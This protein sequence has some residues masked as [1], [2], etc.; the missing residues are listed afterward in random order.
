MEN[1]KQTTLSCINE[2]NICR[3]NM[4]RCK[5]DLIACSQRGPDNLQKLSQVKAYN[6][7]IQQ[8]HARII[9]LQEQIR[10]YNRQLDNLKNVVDNMCSQIKSCNQRLSEI[11]NQADSILDTVQELR[12]RI[13]NLKSQITYEN[14]QKEGLLVAISKAKT[15]VSDVQSSTSQ[16][17]R[18]NDSGVQEFAPI[19]IAWQAVAY[20]KSKIKL[21]ASN[22]WSDVAGS[23]GFSAECVVF[24]RIKGWIKGRSGTRQIARDAERAGCGN[25]GEQAA[26]A[27]TW[28]VDQKGIAPVDYMVN[29]RE[30]DYNSNHA[31]VV[32]G[33]KEGSDLQ[34]PSTWGRNA[35]VCDPWANK[36]YL[37][38]ELKKKMDDVQKLNSWVRN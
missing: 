34:E 24:E 17:L 26:V 22:K 28:L 12:T 7:Q 36:C 31:F 37:A 16:S 25:C 23:A 13:D 4:E 20:V 38:S 15:K 6:Q 27:W 30:G 14:R 29:E 19:D 33:R 2:Y 1:T 35:A 18:G 10:G 8:I 9:Q 11:Q 32:I 5:R 21:G 3:G